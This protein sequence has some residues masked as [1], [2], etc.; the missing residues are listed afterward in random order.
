MSFTQC[1]SPCAFR[2]IGNQSVAVPSQIPFHSYLQHQFMTAFD[3]YLEI[4]RQ[5]DKKLN[6]HLGYN[7]PRAQLIR[8]CP[9]C[10]FKLQ[11][12]PDLEFSIMVTMDGNNSLKRIGPSTQAHEDLFN[13]HS[14]DSDQ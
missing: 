14:I 8:Q 13:S 7:T 4:C 3:I 10:F 1:K 5:V 12:K 9:P 11:G 2:N 6:E